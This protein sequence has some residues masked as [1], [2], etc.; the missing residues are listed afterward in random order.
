VAQQIWVREGKL[1]V[2]VGK[3]THAL[4]RDDCLAMNLDTAVTFHN[5]SRR[6]ARYIVVLSS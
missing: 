2:T 6:V 5:R 1:E 3:T 4:E